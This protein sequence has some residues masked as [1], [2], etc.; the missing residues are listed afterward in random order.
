VVRKLDRVR[1]AERSGVLV[2]KIGP[3]DLVLGSDDVSAGLIEHPVVR[4][5]AL[6]TRQKR[7]EAVEHAKLVQHQQSAPRG[8]LDYSGEV[9]APKLSG[10][11]DGVLVTIERYLPVTACQVRREAR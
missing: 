9:R 11:Q 8:L 1:D 5:A 10:R 2:A 7:T 4:G 3:G 6:P